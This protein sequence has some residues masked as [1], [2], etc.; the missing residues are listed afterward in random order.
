MHYQ[1]SSGAWQDIDPLLHATGTGSFVSGANSWKATFAPLG[2]GGGVSI[3]TM[4]GP[5][6]FDPVGVS[7]VQPQVSA[8]DP[9]TVLYPN[10]WPNVD[11]KYTV[12]ASGVEEHLMLKSAEVAAQFAFATPT[13]S[14]GAG[15]AT[16]PGAKPNVS[17][18]TTVVPQLDPVGRPVSSGTLVPPVVRDASGAPQSDAAPVLSSSGPAVSIGIAPSWLAALPATAFPVDV[19]P[20]WSAGGSTGC[21]KSVDGVGQSNCGVQVG[22]SRSTNGNGGVD[23]TYWRTTVFFD[24]GSLAG[25]HVINAQVSVG[26]QWHGTAADETDQVFATSAYNYNGEGAYFGSFTTAGGS[27][28]MSSDNSAFPPGTNPGLANFYDTQI[29]QGNYGAQVF[30]GGAEVPG[31]FTYQQFYGATLVINFDHVPAP[32]TTYAPASGSSVQGAPALSASTTDADGGTI[33]YQFNVWTGPNGTGTRVSSVSVPAA[34]GATAVDQLVSAANGGP[35]KANTTYYWRAIPNDGYYSGGPSPWASFATAPAP[36]AAPTGVTAADGNGAAVVSWTA[37]ATNGSPV[38]S[39][40][41][42]SNPG[43]IQVTTANGTT[44]TATVTGLTNGQPYTFT[45]V[46]NSAI[47]SSGPSTASNS[48]TPTVQ[49][50]VPRSA[51]DAPTDGAVNVVWVPPAPNGGTAIDS[52]AINAFDN[53]TNPATYVGTIIACATCYTATYTGLIDGHSY[54]LAV[55]AHNPAGYGTPDTGQA[56][57]PTTTVPSAPVGATVIAPGSNAV[58]V[59]WYPPSSAG[60]SPITGYVVN[61]YDL[62]TGYVPASSAAVYCPCGAVELATLTAMIPGH[63]YFHAV[64]AFNTSGFGPPSVTTP[65]GPTNQSLPGAPTNTAV[66]GANMALTATW[67]PPAASGTSA[68]S[69]YQLNAYD[70]ADASV[71]YGTVN[72]PCPTGTVAGSV[73][74][75]ANGH[76]YLVGVFGFNASGFG[77]GG[78]GNVV[79]A[80]GPQAPTNVTAFAGNGQ[81]L[82]TW[83]APSYPGGTPIDSYTIFAYPPTGTPTSQ[84]ITC[85]LNCIPAANPGAGTIS[86][87]IPGLANGTAYTFVVYAHD[88]AG[89]GPGG[90]DTNA[91]TPNTNPAPYPPL[92]QYGAPGPGDAFVA[93]TAPPANTAPVTDYLIQ[94]FDETTPNTVFVGQ[95]TEPGTAT[96]M[97][98]PG[99]T[100]GHIYAFAIYS[101]NASNQYT[102]VATG[103]VT[104][105][106]TAPPFPVT[107]LSV[108]PEDVAALINWA[109]PAGGTA[110]TGYSVQAYSYANYTL[111]PAGNPDTTTLPLDVHTGLVNNTSYAFKVT[112]VNANGTS[113]P[114]TSAPP[115][116]PQNVIGD[117]LSPSNVKAVPADTTAVI[118]WDPPTVGLVP[119]ITGYDIKIYSG[120]TL[121]KTVTTGINTTGTCAT[122]TTADPPIVNPVR[123]PCAVVAGLK[124]GTSYSFVV[125]AILLGLTVG[126]SLPSAAV[127]PAGRPFPPAITTINNIPPAGSVAQVVWTA[128]GARPDGTP[129]NNGRPIVSYTLTATPINDANFNPNATTVTATYTVPYP[130]PG[131]PYTDTITGLYNGTDYNIT[132]IA[133]NSIGDSDPSPNYQFTPFGV[134]FPPINAAATQDPSYISATIN[135][136]PPPQ[137]PDLVPGDNGSPITS[138]T[139]TASPGGA[140]QTVNGNTTTT[141]FT[142]LP[143]GTYTFTITATNLAGT[144]GP[145][146]ASNPVTIAGLPSAP[147]NAYVNTSGTTATVYWTA[148]NSNGSPILSYTVTPQPADVPAQ[149][150]GPNTFSATFSGLTPGTMYNYAVVAT[151]AVGTGPA[152]V[153]VD[154]APGSSYP[155]Y[156]T[157]SH[158]IY[159]DGHDLCLQLGPG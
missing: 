70:L 62:A 25:T 104:P 23:D 99:L 36:P 139:V 100:N 18:V 39:Y 9:S 47:G 42:T 51:E 14:F 49:P 38:T 120:G 26:T 143:P 107:A 5:V 96:S 65:P 135:W 113:L 12:T 61:T 30:F 88:A 134:P 145:S 159:T 111:T 11:L 59:A 15:V 84:T 102:A 148:A 93:W 72:C 110:P 97:V 108:L 66:T 156:Y 105:A 85:S 13:A 27:G 55:Y 45:V 117:L 142:G 33:N 123:A 50:G 101:H 68:I 31:V 4:S 126:T 28:S 131:G 129:G 151:N 54:S 157:N 80:T 10:A 118:S 29:S 44:T 152:A 114:V 122:G 64:Y 127:I 92:N 75:L 158:Y 91:V 81:A 138:Y 83:N 130:D 43:N 58:T 149:T 119:F 103:Q 115:T 40:T 34:S 2:S 32:I 20:T 35:I 77:A 136:N 17:G 71:H 76:Q 57:T 73:T 89:Q 60:A 8:S 6:S 124:N 74:G 125:D 63:T 67:T 98:Y 144:G 109:E 19:D 52:Y 94:A 112:A 86:G 1:D 16:G 128:P 37:S 90:N 79:T 48:V 41:V 7:G 137:Q 132:V 56:V 154:A 3:A 82:V 24:Y 46:A 106:S 150:V 147:G 116:V 155:G 87:V 69:K 133:T 53:A 78:I 22:N 153:A 95:Q 121:V 146:A 21:Y 140:T 141:D